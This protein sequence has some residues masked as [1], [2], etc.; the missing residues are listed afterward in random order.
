MP[1]RTYPIADFLS[2]E[3]EIELL[4]LD[5]QEDE[6]DGDILIRQG[7]VT[8]GG[9]TENIGGSSHY[10]Y[11]RNDS[12][13]SVI[14]DRGGDGRAELRQSS[15]RIEITVTP[16]Y[17]QLNSKR[18]A[19]PRAGFTKL[20]LSTVQYYLLQKNATIVFAAAAES[21]EE[22]GF[23]LFAGGGSGKST[24]LFRLAKEHEFNVLADD[25]VII[26]QGDVHPFP[27]YMDLP[28]DVASIKT[29][30]EQLREKH[31]SDVQE[32]PGEV[33]VPRRFISTIP[34]CIKP[35]YSFFL[36][37]N[38]VPIKHCSKTSGSEATGM[39]VARNRSH[40]SNWT[41]Y[42]PV[43]H[44]FD[45]YAHQEYQ[46]NRDELIREAVEGTSSYK[47]TTSDR[48]KIPGIIVDTLQQ[49]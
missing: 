7:E 42:E 49:G 38:R 32:W 29:D 26:H 6:G 30:V 18:V 45:R 41:T 36:R 11:Y 34:S 13:Q 25:L 44:F 14:D 47:V 20:L 27:R 21:S 23:L 40:A 5:T 31:S 9:T 10:Q 46:D 16:E 24:T 4:P 17:A 1:T 12:R 22:S 43:R 28:L 15:D 3:S 37:P 19:F 33:S 2:I 35:E 39:A 8:L 48:A